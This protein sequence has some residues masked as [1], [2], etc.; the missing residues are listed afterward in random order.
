MQVEYKELKL[1]QHPGV[2]HILNQKWNTFGLPLY[3]LQ[4]IAYCLMVIP[5]SI[6]VLLPI[7]FS[8]FTQ[9]THDN[10]VL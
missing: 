9:G 4:L 6:L 10:R 1:L 8:E 5:L 3:I 7:I 2:K